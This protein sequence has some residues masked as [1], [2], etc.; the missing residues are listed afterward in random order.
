MPTVNARPPPHCTMW[1]TRTLLFI[2]STTACLAL[3]Y[4]FNRRDANDHLCSRQGRPLLFAAVGNGL[5]NQRWELLSQLA[6]AR[7]L[8]LTFVAGQV[9]MEQFNECEGAVGAVPFGSVFSID[10][11]QEWGSL[12]NVTVAYDLTPELQV[13]CRK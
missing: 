13:C 9:S 2:I 7:K 11:L 8:G 12:N 1:T 3:P 4:T 5:S 10:A 6:T